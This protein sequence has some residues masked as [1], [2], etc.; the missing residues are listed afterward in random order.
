[1]RNKFK[2]GRSM[3]EVRSDDGAMA[4][5][6]LIERWM[7]TGLVKE[8]P[9]HFQLDMVKA[10][11]GQRLYNES[12]EDV[13]FKRLSIPLMYRVMMGLEDIGIDV[14]GSISELSKW[15]RLKTSCNYESQRDLRDVNGISAEAEMVMILSHEITKELAQLKEKEPLTITCFTLA[16]VVLELETFCPRQAILVNYE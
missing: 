15:I 10:L 4:D 12:I 1:M 13:Q 8:V 5:K 7:P 14:R 2:N 6:K 3:R 16:P 9:K 11:E